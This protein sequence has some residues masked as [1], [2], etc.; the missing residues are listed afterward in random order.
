MPASPHQLA[1]LDRVLE[2]VVLLDADMTQA[3]A[4][5]GLTKSRAP[6][7]WALQQHGPST[8]KA[9]ADRLG[10]TPRN[11]TGLVDGLVATGFVTRQ[12]HPT[13]RHATL[14][15]LTAQ[16]RAVMEQMVADHDELAQQL[17]AAFGPRELE[18]FAAALGSVLDVIRAHLDDA[19]EEAR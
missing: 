6:V 13:D 1:T 11:V 16:G 2:L 18:G 7:V 19:S 3:L 4:R 14:V 10:T 9:L 15:S 17:F 8:Q 12:P 5:D